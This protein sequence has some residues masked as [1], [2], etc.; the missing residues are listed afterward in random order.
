MPL[1]RH[2]PG[3]LI[4][5]PS[6][7]LQK[8]HWRKSS[9]SCW[10]L[11]WFWFNW[12]QENITARSNLGKKQVAEE[13]DLLLLMLSTIEPRHAHGTTQRSTTSAIKRFYNCTPLPAKCFFLVLRLH[14]H[15][16][17]PTRPP[18]QALSLF[19]MACSI[20]NQ[21]NK[22]RKPIECFHFCNIFHPR[23]PERFRKYIKPLWLK[24]LNFVQR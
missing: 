5:F 18:K 21:Q 17:L 24:T 3:A 7:G 22:P 19:G 16:A 8:H 13:Q 20:K 6:S 15:K 2:F 10:I 12:S 14:R 1:Y 23:I 4:R 11:K 9:D